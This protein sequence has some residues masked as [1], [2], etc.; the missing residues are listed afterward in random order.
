[1]IRPHSTL[2]EV[3]TDIV[4]DEHRRLRDQLLDVHSGLGSGDFGRTR[5]CIAK[6]MAAIGPHFRYEEEALHPALAAVFGYEPWQPLFSAHNHMIESLQRLAALAEGDRAS[7]DS[8]GAAAGLLGSI[9]PRL[10]GCDGVAL[11]IERLPNRHVRRILD[12]REAAL[13]D[14]HDLVTWAARYRARGGRKA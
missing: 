14:G 4:R 13:R 12:C 1:M 6:L 7:A 3:C 10:S 9:L 11:W 8:L 2:A 5:L